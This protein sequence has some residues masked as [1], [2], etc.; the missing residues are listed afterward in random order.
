MIYEILD[1]I[2][3][4]QRKKKQFRELFQRNII[5]NQQKDHHIF[6]FQTTLSKKKAIINLENKKDQKCF[7]GQY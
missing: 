7:F 2:Q 1:G 3:N 5:T 6:H 4:F